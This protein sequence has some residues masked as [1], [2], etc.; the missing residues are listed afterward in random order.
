MTKKTS[1][2]LIL[3][4]LLLV[5]GGW[6]GLA[7]AEKK[8]RQFAVDFVKENT[9]WQLQLPEKVQ[10][11]I[12]NP[13]AITFVNAA[14]LNQEKTAL[15]VTELAISINI[16]ALF[17]NH[18]HIQN[19][20]ANIK[21]L[22]INQQQL[23]ALQAKNQTET[24]AG[25]TEEPW[26]QKIIIDSI[27]LHIND[28]QF[29]QKPI[30]I[31]AKNSQ[32]NIQK[33]ALN[34]QQA[35]APQLA[36]NWQVKNQQ[37]T[38]NNTSVNNIQLVGDIKQQKLH[39]ALQAHW[40]KHQ[41]NT[42]ATA[43]FKNAL[44]LNIKTLELAIKEFTDEQLQEIQQLQASLQSDDNKQPNTKTRSD[45]KPLLETLV[46]QT[47]NINAKSISL[48]QP[49]LT[50]TNLKLSAK[51]MPLMQKQEW[52]YHSRAFSDFTAKATLAEGF[53]AK[54]HI[55]D[56][57]LAII[58]QEQTLVL[59][60][61]TAQ[62]DNGDIKLKGSADLS[63]QEVPS[64]W[65]GELNNIDL[66]IITQ[67]TNF[68]STGIIDAGFDASIS[69][70]VDYENIINYTQGDI[71]AKGENLQIS[72]INIDKLVSTIRS[73]REISWT[74]IGAIGFFGPIGLLYSTAA[75]VGSG[76]ITPGKGTSHITQLDINAT[77]NGP[78][79]TFHENLIETKKNKI[80]FKGQIN[81]QSEAFKDFEIAF[82]NKYY[83]A[84]FIQEITGTYKKPNISLTNLS[85]GF[86][87]N[88]AGDLLTLKPLR[89]RF[90]KAYYQGELNK[91]L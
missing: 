50:L 14:L 38:L 32:L 48:E 1:T 28:L 30:T 2:V 89:A 23:N 67:K 69:N 15:G 59:E 40:H 12:Q 8:A 3:V 79:V 82:L 25:T 26:L 73:A 52:F 88:T 9:P 76:T 29:K 46:L 72:N 57:S 65:Q 68:P 18:L 44:N 55:Q 83:C 70:T 71:F 61:L 45:S 91:N 39:A 19:I 86:I 54:Q 43:S 56:L 62:L 78:W 27:E 42:E 85:A 36:F 35:I 81:H 80:S 34:L 74:D 66:Q 17:K 31:S 11:S 5:A 16:D 6:F 10:W 21:K 4:I 33:L 87:L 84:T 7:F 24:E 49:P 41:L 77:N 22:Q 20:Q 37:L 47:L 58:N 90:C 60:H 63:Q 64:K 53:Y 51:N 13:G 75:S